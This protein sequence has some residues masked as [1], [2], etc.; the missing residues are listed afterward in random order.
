MWSKVFDTNCRIIE[1]KL[2]FVLGGSSNASFD[3]HLANWR[4][5]SIV[6]DSESSSDEEF[7]DAEGKF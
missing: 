2:I 4:M 1:R 6:R 5:E 3:M 7:F